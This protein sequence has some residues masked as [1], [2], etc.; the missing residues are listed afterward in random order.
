M[1]ENEVAEAF[2]WGVLAGA[3]CA[4]AVLITLAFWARSE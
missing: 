1:C 4:T 2:L 3:A